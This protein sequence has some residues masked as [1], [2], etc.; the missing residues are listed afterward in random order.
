MGSTK[1]VGVGR[2]PCEGQKG[3]GPAPMYCRHPQPSF[4]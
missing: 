4:I 3:E 1:G 2:V